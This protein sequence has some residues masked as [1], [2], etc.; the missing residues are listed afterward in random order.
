VLIVDLLKVNCVRM[1]KWSLL[2]F[3]VCHKGRG[4]DPAAIAAQFNQRLHRIAD[5]PGSR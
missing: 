5:K 2:C 4:E 3:N 1:D